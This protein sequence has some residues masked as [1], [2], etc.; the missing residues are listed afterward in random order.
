MQFNGKIAWLK[1][2]KEKY[3]GGETRHCSKMLPVPGEE[4]EDCR[5]GAEQLGG[6]RRSFTEIGEASASYD[7]VWR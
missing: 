3:F 7:A 5:R 4:K 1:K 2:L 6:L